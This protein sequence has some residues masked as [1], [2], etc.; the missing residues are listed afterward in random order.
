MVDCLFHIKSLLRDTHIACDCSNRMH[1][2]ILTTRN[3]TT[4]GREMKRKRFRSR[5]NEWMKSA[6]Q[7]SK[8]KIIAGVTPLLQPKRDVTMLCHS[9]ALLSSQ[10]SSASELFRTSA[11]E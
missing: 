8:F 2:L 10:D 3:Q 11:L 7:K 4:I 5:L 1:D 9:H 6:R